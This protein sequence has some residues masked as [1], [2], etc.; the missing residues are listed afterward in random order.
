MGYGG[1]VRLGN[2]AGSDRPT[3]TTVSTGVPRVLVIEDDEAFADV[4]ARALGADD[5]ELTLADR[6]MQGLELAAH[7][8]FGLVIL[9]LLLPDIDGISLLKRLLAVRP[10]QQVLIVSALSN[11]EAKVRCLDLGAADYLSKPFALDELLARTRARLRL[12]Q[13][14]QT[15][16]YYRQGT[17]TLDVQRR[18]AT[19]EGRIVHLS[20]REFFLLEYLMRREGEVCTR[21]EILE[22]VWGYA[23]DP[24]TNVVDVYV[25]R[26]RQK[27]GE[28]RIDTIRNVGYG[29][30]GA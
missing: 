27:I 12:G 5:F 7:E 4:L 8:E 24:G 1:G 18:V 28:L 13:A 11:V 22:S 30:N 20:E 6:G 19:C 17:L 10:E 23:H 29:I 21:E 26:L 14:R 2:L 15:G 16:R 25:R 9:D 3:S